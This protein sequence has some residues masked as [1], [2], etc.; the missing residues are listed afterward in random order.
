MKK[1]FI[2]IILLLVVI[3]VGA[4][5]AG[6]YTLVQTEKEFLL[7]EKDSFNYETV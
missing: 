5:F 2:A 6:N 1:F 4:T 3:G 7:L